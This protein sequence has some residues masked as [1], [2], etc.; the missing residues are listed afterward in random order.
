MGER[1]EVYSEKLFTES[2]RTYFFNVKE[3]RKGI[4]FKYCRE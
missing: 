2:E 3:N 4:I 1:G